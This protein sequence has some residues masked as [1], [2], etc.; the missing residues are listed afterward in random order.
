[1][2]LI[3]LLI[4]LY[5]QVCLIGKSRTYS[6]EKIKQITD[7]IAQMLLTS[8]YCGHDKDTVHVSA[9]AV[10][11]ERSRP[12]SSS[13]EIEISLTN[14]RREEEEDNT[15]A[16]QSSTRVFTPRRTEETVKNCT[17][18]DKGILEEIIKTVA[19]ELLS[20]GEACNT[21]SL[22]DGVHRHEKK[23]TW[24]KGGKLEINY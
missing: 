2:G 16:N 17:Q 18:V 24:N 14:H 12:R 8:R 5:T 9:Q 4:M 6:A 20:R 22:N 19:A 10:S 15:R 11:D 23:K 13:H 21:L 7:D 1:M 3:S